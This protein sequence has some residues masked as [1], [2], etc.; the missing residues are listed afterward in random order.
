MG[1]MTIYNAVREVPQAAQK[2][3]T[4]GRLNGMTDINPMW[5]IEKLTET[6]GAAGFGWYADI[7][8]TWLDAGEDGEVIASVEIK[9]FVKVGDEWSKGIAGIG[10]SKFIAKE[11]RG[12]FTDDECYKKA[13]TDALSVACKALGVG[14]DIYF[15]KSDSKYESTHAG[16]P[17]E[18]KTSVS[19]V[20]LPT[21]QKATDDGSC[22]CKKC[23]TPLSEAV[24]AYSLR[25]FGVEL[26]RTCQKTYS[27]G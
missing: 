24:K 3:I 1:N 13:Y 19:S 5:R 18:Q 17:K 11:S 14:A 16:Q 22:A 8:R 9:L 20:K 2:K 23:R 6:F 12:V 21:A 26:C 27:E 15:A 10:G 4:G 7:V 25:V